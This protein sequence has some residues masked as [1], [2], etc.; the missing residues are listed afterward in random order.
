MEP[1]KEPEPMAYSFDAAAKITRLREGQLQQLGEQLRIEGD[2]LT[3]PQ[4]L[5]CCFLNGC[6]QQ[7]LSAGTVIPIAEGIAQKTEQEARQAVVTIDIGDGR[8]ITQ[9][10]SK[11][12]EA[13]DADIASAPLP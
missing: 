9:P 1:E 10:M 6:L 12:A 7:G 4:L 5:A 13:L 8:K 2:T 11:G 3:Y